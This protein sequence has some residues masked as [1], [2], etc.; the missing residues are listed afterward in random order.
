[1][2]VLAAA[3]AGWFSAKAIDTTE[4]QHLEPRVGVVGARRGRR[5]LTRGLTFDVPRGVGHLARRR[6]EPQ[7]YDRFA[8]QAHSRGRLLFDHR[9]R[10]QLAGNGLDRGYEATR[11]HER[12]GP[13]AVH[14]HDLGCDPLA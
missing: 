1:M 4:R 5:L 14:R 13:R 2:T 7:R 11:S 3:P 6:C 8:P 12:D 9:P 10:G